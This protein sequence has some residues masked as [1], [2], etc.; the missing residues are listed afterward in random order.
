MSRNE[1]DDG[2]EYDEGDQYEYERKRKKR[3]KK[4]HSFFLLFLIAVFSVLCYRGIKNW[5]APAPAAYE[6]TDSSAVLDEGTG[7]S[8]LPEDTAEALEAMAKINPRFDPIVQDPAKYPERL[9]ESLGRNPELLDFTLDYPQKKGTFA[10]KIDLSG[11]Y[12]KDQIPLLLQW[13]EDWGYAPYGNGIIALD[14]CGPTCLSMV[15]VGLTGDLSKNP[16][17]VADFSEQHGYLDE[18]SNSTL[19]TLMSEGAGKLGLN[20]REIPL[21]KSRMTQELSEGHPIICC[22]GPG[23]FTTQGHFLVICE[24]QDGAFVIRDPN[25]KERS[26]KTWSYERLKPQIRDLWAFSA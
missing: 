1:Y 18:K 21:S 8:A 26:R 20:S 22:M 4:H 16:K 3:H 23:D 12:Q 11:K 13:D 14:G 19:W 24:F 5:T 10:G 7:T 17:A 2:Y 9:L 6:E 25:S 15:V